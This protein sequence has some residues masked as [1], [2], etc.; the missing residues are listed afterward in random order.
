MR[1]G[2]YTPNSG[3][4]G[5][6]QLVVELAQRAE[7]AGWDGFFL[8]DHLTAWR[9]PVSDPWVMLGA[10]AAQTERI[11][12]GPLIVPLARRRAQ[13]VALE[14]ATLARLAPGRVVLGVGLG[15]P[16]DF[17]RFG[18]DADWRVRARKV[19]ESLA[20]IRESLPDLPVWVSGEWPR[21]Q[22]FHGVELADG[23]FP[24]HRDGD[25][26]GRSRPAKRRPP[27]RR[28]PTV[29][30]ATSRSGASRT[31]GAASSPTTR[32][33]ASRGGWSR[34]S[35]FRPKSC[36]ASRTQARTA[37]SGPRRCRF[38][39]VHELA[40]LTAALVRMESVNP[41]LDPAG[42]GE[43]PVAQAVVDWA[44]SQGCRS[45]WTSSLPVARPCSSTGVAAVVAASCCSATSTRSAVRRWPIRSEATVRD[46]R[47]HGRGAYDMK[48]GVAAAL[49]AARDFDR[50]GIDG[51]VIVA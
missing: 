34:A 18:E 31:T 44:H 26:F 39:S 8:W 3:A 29:P 13:K 15:A 28:S 5:D 40:E 22:P 20:V 12:I 17:T 50:E 46:G 21:M 48:G 25:R 33:Q 14:A 4:S 1:F 7:A 30:G 9:A 49:V 16:E 23:A 10:V 11:T 51:S 6:P 19:E 35:C 27:S 47:V 37:T 32:R 42:S 41:S 24:I 43:A 36:C 38:D 2:F 45:S